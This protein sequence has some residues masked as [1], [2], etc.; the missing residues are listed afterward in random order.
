MRGI[1]LI[2]IATAASLSMGIASADEAEHMEVVVVTAAKPNSLEIPQ[3]VAVE[4]LTPSIDFLELSIE[5]PQLDQV[6][7]EVELE[8]ARIDVALSTEIEPKS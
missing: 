8:R 2:V 1:R 4:R 7:V 5:A 3:A 6:E